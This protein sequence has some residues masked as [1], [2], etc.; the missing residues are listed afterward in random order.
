MGFLGKLVLIE[1]FEN[2]GPV[3]AAY[4]IK[5]HFGE[6]KGYGFVDFEDVATAKFLVEMGSVEL[7][8]KNVQVKPYKVKDFQFSSNTVGIFD[9]KNFPKKIDNLNA[10]D[11]FFYEI[12]ENYC[13]ENLNNQLQHNMKRAKP[14]NKGPLSCFMNRSCEHLWEVSAEIKKLRDLRCYD[15]ALQME[16]YFGFLSFQIVRS[17]YFEKSLWN[18]VDLF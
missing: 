5:N 1:F 15:L 13:N 16:E 18:K 6:S 4:S 11:S 9:K 2:F 14:H 12:E 10:K 17:G 7:R 3:K 8:K